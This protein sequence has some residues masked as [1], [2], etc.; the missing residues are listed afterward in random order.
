[1]YVKD[2][3]YS[4]NRCFNYIRYSSDGI[5]SIGED[6]PEVTEDTEIEDSS[7]NS[8]ETVASSGDATSIEHDISNLYHV[9]SLWFVLWI[10][11]T[12]KKI[13]HNAFIKNTNEV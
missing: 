13:I 8:T 9:V 11:I 7:E 12:C 10:I 2:N 6:S 4:F 3:V 1:M 5:D